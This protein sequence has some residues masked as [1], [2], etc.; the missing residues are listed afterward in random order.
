M[1]LPEKRYAE[2]PGCSRRRL[3]LLKKPKPISGNIGNRRPDYGNLLLRP[4]GRRDNS[5]LVAICVSEETRYALGGECVPPP[6][7]RGRERDGIKTA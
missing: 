4:Y 6:L 7:W 5:A 1:E 2:I 3:E